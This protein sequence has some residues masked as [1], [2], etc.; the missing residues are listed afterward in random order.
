MIKDNREVYRAINLL[1]AEKRTSLAVLRTGIA[2][3][4]LPLSVFTILIAT[5]RYYDISNSLHFMV[6][7]FVIC[8]ALVI[9]GVYLIYRSFRK[10]RDI[11]RKIQ[12]IKKE[13]KSMDDIIDTC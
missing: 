11:D 10:L 3:F 1:L 13:Q 5:S 2:I 7:L 6:P 12:E 8:L 9:L 4:T